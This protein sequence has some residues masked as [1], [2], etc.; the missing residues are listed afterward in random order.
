[1][2]LIPGEGGVS[3]I[4]RDGT[5]MGRYGPHYRLQS[6]FCS[7]V[8]IERFRPGGMGRIRPTLQNCTPASVV[9]SVSDDRGGDAP[10]RRT[11]QKSD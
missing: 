4:R 3:Q 11:L 6:G 8:R 10:I 9:S 2:W 5:G 7:V 1:M